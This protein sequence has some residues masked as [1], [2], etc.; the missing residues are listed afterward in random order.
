MDRRTRLKTLHFRNFVGGQQQFRTTYYDVLPTVS[1]RSTEAFNELSILQIEPLP[2]PI[3]TARPS[4]RGKVIFYVF[5][6]VC[7]FTG[8][9][10]GCGP[11]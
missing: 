3:V 1:S 6:R 10:G 4:S 5:S 2:L 8:G 9:G 11:M 7:L